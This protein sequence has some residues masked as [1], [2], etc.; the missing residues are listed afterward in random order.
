[1]HAGLENA[2]PSACLPWLW[3]VEVGWTHADTH[4]QI[5]TPHAYN[6]AADCSD[7]S[8]DE[9]TEADMVLHILEKAVSRMR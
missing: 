4:T 9:A 7:A 1:M 5:I 8:D 2:G 3:R 6:V